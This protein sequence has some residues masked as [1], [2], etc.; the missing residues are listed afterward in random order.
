MSFLITKSSNEGE[1][2]LDPFGGSCTTA[3]AC[4]N[5]RRNYICIEKQENYVNVCN[6]RLKQDL[7]F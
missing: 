7:L 2:V 4:K 5:L 6:E 1:I 3:L